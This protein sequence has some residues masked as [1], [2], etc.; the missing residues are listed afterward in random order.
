M[1]AVMAHKIMASW[2]A[3][4]RSYSRMVQ[5]CL[6]I[7]ANVLS[8]A[9]CRFLPFTFLALSQP[10]MALGTVPAARTDW[11]AITA[12]AGSWSCPAKHSI[13]NPLRLEGGWR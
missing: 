6:L 10:R 11:E 1:R 7:Q 3:G 5:R 9:M 2:L 4:R 8:T 13:E 12:A